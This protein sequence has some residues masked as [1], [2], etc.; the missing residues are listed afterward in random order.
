[1]K[2]DVPYYASKKDTDCGPLALKMALEYL[3]ED[4]SFEEIAEKERQLD[5]GMVWS[6]GIARAAKKFGFPVKLISISNF[7]HEENDIEFYKKYA[8]NKA[9]IVLKELSEELGDTVE[10]KDMSIEE[11]LKFVSEDSVP[12]VLVNWYVI[13]EKEGF[14]GHF[15]PVVG[16]DEENIYVHNPGLARAQA[17]LPI[18]RDL[19]VKAWESKGT[20]KDTIVIFRK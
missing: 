2:I 7:S 1:M 15:L 19:F 17:Y 4:H 13:A 5:S 9:M 14:N 12:I 16:Y 11:L 6:G 10:E 8:D 3:G 20:D 18:K